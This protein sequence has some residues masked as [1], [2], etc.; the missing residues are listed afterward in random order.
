MSLARCSNYFERTRSTSAPTPHLHLAM[1]RPGRPVE[2]R[3]AP[4]LEPL[5]L[6]RHTVEPGHVAPE[7]DGAHAE[8]VQHPVQLVE[9]QIGI[10][11]RRLGHGRSVSRCLPPRPPLGPS[12]AG[13]PPWSAP[14]GHRA[15][16]SGRA[17]SPRPTSP[18]GAAGWLAPRRPSGCRARGEFPR[19]PRG[20]PS[21]SA[22]TPARSATSATLH[23]GRHPQ[24][25]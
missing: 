25:L 12:S 9:P 23:A 24:A 20:G 18:G 21:Q 7:D 10:S 3:R 17:R 14:C 15:A 2:Q 22:S 1:S 5:R 16:G 8:V 19:P 6:Q 11:R 4:V 13:R